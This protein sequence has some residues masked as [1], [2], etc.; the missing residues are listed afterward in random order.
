MIVILDRATRSAHAFFSALDTCPAEACPDTKGCQSRSPTSTCILGL[1]GDHVVCL[2]SFTDVVG[3]MACECTGPQECV[4]L[5]PDHPAILPILERL[6]ALV[7][8]EANRIARVRSETETRLLR[9]G[10]PSNGQRPSPGV[11]LV[12]R[13]TQCAP[14]ALADLPLQTKESS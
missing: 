11:T 7:E 12:E 8:P 2:G 1:A 6:A 3:V 4:H 10:A 5:N 14:Q 13:I 9:R